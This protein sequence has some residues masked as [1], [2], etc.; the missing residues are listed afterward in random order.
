MVSTTKNSSLAVNLF[1]NQIHGRE[2]IHEEIHGRE[3][4]HEQIHS[5][6]RFQRTY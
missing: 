2:F 6:C 3:F 1:M 4:V 5:Q